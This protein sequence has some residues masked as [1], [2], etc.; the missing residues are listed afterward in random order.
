[1]KIAVMGTGGVGGY[2]G[3]RLAA[4]GFDVTF[5]ARG[6]HLAAI[7]RDGLKVESEKGD[8]HIYPTQA[9]DVPADVGS[10]DY[11]LF[12]VKLWDTVAA[13]TAIRPL[14]DAH[15]AVISLQNGVNAEHQLSD[16]L[17]PPHVMGGI[18]QIA[19]LIVAPGII[20]HTG[21]MANIVF[22]EF[23][24]ERSQRSENLLAAFQTAD[25]NAEISHDIEK[26]IWQKFVFLVGLS[27]L[28]SVT[29][30]SIGPVR[31]D[32]HT[33]E[34]LVLVMMETVAVA[35]AKGID[36]GDEFVDD[37]LALIDTLPVQ[38][39]SSMQL[40]LERGNRLELDWLSGAVVRMGQEHGI[41]TPANRLI[42][43]ALK[44][45]KDGAD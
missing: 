38:M 9:T 16:I 37:R 41:D 1:M 10:V 5:I 43:S 42:Y 23:D 29:G 14:I 7:R 13:A 36:I 34:L 3:G 6:E 21:T 22:G 24:G 4:A 40:D 28:T 44:L 8:L 15:T 20:R 32:P 2:F 31:E 17:G 11:V 25:V 26:T 30:H 27:A 39:T 19:A 35:Q 18:A 12:A 33:R 45:S